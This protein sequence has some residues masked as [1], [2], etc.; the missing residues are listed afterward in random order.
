M[1]DE[2][3]DS[4]IRTN[5]AAEVSGPGREV[6]SFHLHRYLSG[7]LSEA[8]C[9]RVMVTVGF[10]DSDSDLGAYRIDRN[11]GHSVS[12]GWSHR[13]LGDAWRYGGGRLMWE[14]PSGESIRFEVTAAFDD[15][16]DG[17]S[18]VPSNVLG[19]ATVRDGE[20]LDDDT[21]HRLGHQVAEAVRVARR[22]GVRLFFDEQRDRPVKSLLYAMMDRLPEWSGCDHSAAVLLTHDLDAIT[23]EDSTRGSFNVL[24]ER[25]FFEHDDEGEQPDRLVGMTVYGDGDQT[26]L[27]DAL[28]RRRDEP[29]LMYRRTEGGWQPVHGDGEEKLTGWYELKGRPQEQT[30]ALVPLT[31]G[32]GDDDRRDLLGFLT[33]SWRREVQLPPSIG[34][35]LEAVGANLGR[36]LR[37]SSLYTMSVRKLWVARRVRQL[38]EAGIDSGQK[39]PEVLEKVIGEVSEVVANHVDVPSFAIGYLP[40]EGESR[41]LRFAHPHGWTRY[42]DLDLQVDVPDEERVDSGVSALAIRLGRPVV[43]AGGYGEGA[44]QE[45]KNYLWVDEERGELFDARAV[46]R[47]RDEFEPR[48]TPLRDYYKPARETAYATLAYPMVFANRQRGVLTVEVERSTDWLWWTGFGG[49]LFW[50][51]IAREVAMAVHWLR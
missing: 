37:H 30:V 46:G 3:S 32:S 28:A 39:G 16:I 17:E 20:R 22:N 45:F 14:A 50:D 15:E 31:A 23:L 11:G 42:D 19:F 49:H 18:D 26:V 34:E 25:V 9:E 13:D 8:R 5:G 12:A 6:F 33:L 48:S 1:N 43:L 38:V 4:D 24:A 44:D 41:T 27:G 51:T 36:L 10:E 7:W 47:D 2:Q 29:Y 40:D 21:L 35:V